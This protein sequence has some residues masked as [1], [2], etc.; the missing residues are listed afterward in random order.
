MTTDNWFTSSKL[1]GDLLLKQITLLGMLRKNKPDIRKEFVTGKN[2]EV[3]SSLFGFRSRPALMSYVVR[4]N[5]AVVVLSTMH[6]DSEEHKTAGTP[7]MILDYNATRAACDGV[8][9]LCHNCSVEKK[10][11]R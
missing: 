3:G 2:R 6:N 8:D 11:V 9:Q 7:H 4:N 5:K 1:A 10:T